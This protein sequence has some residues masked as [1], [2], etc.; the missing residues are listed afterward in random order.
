MVWLFFGRA[1]K[2]VHL[3]PGLVAL[4]A[5]PAV[6]RAVAKDARAAGAFPPEGGAGERML[7]GVGTEKR[8]VAEARGGHQLGCAGAVAEGIRS[9][10]DGGGPAELFR[11]VALTVQVDPRKGFRRGHVGVGL[12]VGAADGIPP[13]R[14]D[15]L[16]D[17]RE[18]R[19]LLALDVL[20]EHGLAAHVGERGDFVH[21]RQ[22]GAGGDEALVEALAPVPLPDGVEVRV[23]DQVEGVFHQRR[24]RLIAIR[25]SEFVRS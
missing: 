13:A 2:A 15:V 22:H 3:A 6:N 14:A 5:V 20:V 1:E 4:A 19:R 8:E 10:G 17:F 23:A 21:E 11:E 12:Q 18:H 25:S 7:L 9:P 16:Q 24:A